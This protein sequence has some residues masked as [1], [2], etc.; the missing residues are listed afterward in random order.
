MMLRYAF[1]PSELVDDPLGLR[2]W[3]SNQ[4]YTLTWH[5]WREISAPVLRGWAL[6]EYEVELERR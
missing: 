5:R 4:G 2:S 1:V 6:V 3:F